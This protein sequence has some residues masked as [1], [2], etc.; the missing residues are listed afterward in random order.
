MTYTTIVIIAMMILIVAQFCAL[1]YVRITYVKLKEDYE[2]FQ[3]SRNTW[4]DQRVESL[5][6]MIKEAQKCLTHISWD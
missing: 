3:H 4:H 2:N 5:R 1:V 6:Q